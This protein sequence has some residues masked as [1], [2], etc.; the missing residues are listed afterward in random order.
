M[1]DLLT[2]DAV[3]DLNEAEFVEL[4]GDVAE[5]CPW[6]AVGAAAKRPYR[7]REEMIGVFIETM[8]AESPVGRFGLVRS[9]P[10][11]GSRA[12]MADASTGEQAEAGL[13]SLSK[14]D[15]DRLEALN[16]QYKAK[17]GFPFILAVRGATKDQVLA[18]LAERLDHS[19]EAELEAALA[20]IE[21]IFRF[22]IEDRVAP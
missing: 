12:K 10:D 11:L 9:H 21:R 1:A 15:Y 6:I 7:D 22:R 4:F 18:S 3:N 13:T 17:F 2:I 5:H 19:R 16:A 14:D 8:R 20:E